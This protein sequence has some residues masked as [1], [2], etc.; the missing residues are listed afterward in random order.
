MRFEDLRL[1]EPLLRAL[2]TQGY[3]NPTPIQITAIP[4]LLAGRDVVGCAQTGTGKTAAFALPILQRLSAP[5]THSHQPR[6]TAQHPIRALVLCPTR[7]LAKQIHDSFQTYGQFTAVRQAVIF[8]GVGQNPQVR[9]I[10]AG[11]DVLIA[12]P[13]RLLDLMNQRL[14]SLNAVEILVLDEADRMLDMGFLPDIRRILSHLP[15]QRQSMLFSATMPPP[16]RTLANDILRDPVPVEVARVSSPAVTVTQWVYHV[17][18]RQKSDLLV[19]LLARAPQDRALVF[20]RTKRGADKLTRHL[21]E[22]GV[23]AAAM[24]GNK[25]QGA[26]TRALEEFRSARTPVLV[27]TDLAARGLD[28]D[29][30]AKVFNFDLTADPETYIHRIGRTGRAGASGTAVTFCSNAERAS[31][32]DIERLLRTPLQT[33]KPPAASGHSTH[34]RPAHSHPARTPSGPSHHGRTNHGHTN[35]GHTKP[36]HASTGRPTP[37]HGRST[38]THAGQSHTG[39]AKPGHPTPVHAKPGH[40]KPAPAKPNH[41]TPGP[42]QHAHAKPAHTPS[43]QPTRH[44]GSHPPHPAGAGKTGARKKR[45]RRWPRPQHRA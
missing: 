32:R 40:P 19:R 24:H 15:H 9:A 30:I 11:V 29:D 35:H 1:A 26:R 21:V 27:A 20:T 39:H 18:P 17:E 7:E 13:G 12:T 43:G 37:G 28:V 22:A 23:R 44:P 2:R 8:G 25:S 6:A 45:R 38:Q 14:V 10:R 31:L 34:N 36:H 42:N 33:A 4:H 3:A 41:S 16:I 5:T